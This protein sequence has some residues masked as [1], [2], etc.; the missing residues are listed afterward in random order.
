MLDF[1]RKHAQSWMIKAALGAVVVVFIFWGIWA[2]RGGRQQELLKIGDYVITVAE[3][4][5]YYQNMRDRYQSLYGERF[6]EEMARKLNLK[7]RAMKDLVNR[8]LLLQEAR[9]EGLEVTQGEVEA[10]IHSNPA[11]QKD[12]LFDKATYI[13]TLQRARLT[14]KEF[15]ANQR[16]RLLINKLQ[17]LVLASVKV[18][19]QEV[20][21][22][23][24]QAFEK[25]NLDMISL[26]PA[27]FKDVSLPPEEVKEYFFK[28]KEEFKLPARVKIRYLLFDPKDYLK[29]ISV[30]PKEVEDYYENNKEKFGQ[31][32]RVK[33]SHILIKADPKD[34]EG[35]EKARQR[36]E[37]IRE[38]AVKGKNFAQL[39]K[40]YSEDPGTK[41]R[42]GDIG[43]IS[44]GMVVPEFEQAAFSMK[45]GEIS[46]VIQTQFGFHI[47]KVDEVQEA[48]IQ[49][50]KK[51][52]AQ[53]EVL[54][55]NRQARGMAYDL[56]DQAFAEASKDKSLDKF[57]EEKKLTVKETPLFSVDDKVDLDPKLKSM[58][59]SMGKGD[60]TPPIRVGETFA[61]LQAVEKQEARVPDLKE[62]EGKVTEALRKEKQKEKALAKA[63]EILGKLE[64]G[65]DFKTEAAKEGLKVEETGFFPRASAPPKISASEDLRKSLAT[66]SLKNP[67]PEAPIFQDG[68]YLIFRLKEVKGIEP[69]QFKSQKENFRR[70]LLMQ[71]QETVMASWLEDLLEKAKARGDYKE[72]QPVSEAI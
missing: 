32:K 47:L 53:I 43:F 35:M 36:A 44:R 51:V 72:L 7:E 69:E 70:G 8:A 45:P 62:V 39:A 52:K 30:S 14:P 18:S 56:A 57:A 31:P 61:V 49:P 59:L 13:R 1:M 17:E 55:K 6:T 64:K 5:N 34:K 29:Q 9:R 60:I 23:Y 42:G 3:A 4:R 54:L 38:E 50:L 24:R 25:I 15:E 11:F 33:V 10:F 21:D 67:Y 12:G 71:K 19:D 68:K 40:K 26:N 37:A 48:S 63:K 16:E 28:H 27:D 22:A 2:P 20:L 58:A 46:S 41:D 66:L 65:A